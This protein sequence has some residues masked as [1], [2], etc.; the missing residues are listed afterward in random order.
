MLA[1]IRLASRFSIIHRAIIANAVPTF[2]C[3]MLLT[4]TKL[5]KTKLI[6]RFNIKVTI[7][8]MTA[9][10]SPIIVASAINTR[11]ISFFLAPKLRNTPISL[12][13]SIT[14]A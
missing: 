5:L 12:V 10:T 3:A 7:I 13:L 6:I 14:D 2:N 4:P 11:E 9:E 1:G 8:A